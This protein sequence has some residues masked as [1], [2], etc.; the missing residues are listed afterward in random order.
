MKINSKLTLLFLLISLIPLAVI[1]IFSYSMA[2]KALTQQVLN[3]L[4]SL[5]VVQKNRVESI[6]AQNLERLVLVSSR[7]QL[8]LSLE[9]FIRDPRSEYQD[10]MN[11][12]LLDARSSISGF[13]NISVLTLNGKVVASTDLAKIYTEHSDEEF[14]I[15]GQIENSADIFFLDEDQNL[16]AYLSGPLYLENKLL[17]VVVIE[18]DLDNI[19]SLVKD[20]S[21]LGETGETLLAKIDGNGDALFLTPLRFDEKAALR[22]TVPKD[23][24][25][26]PITQAL[27]KN[28]WLFSDAVDYRR[29]P[30]LAATQYIGKTDWGLVAKVDKAEAFAPIIQLRNLVVLIIFVSSIVVIIFSFYV[31]R[32]ITKPIINLTQMASKISEGDLS[33]RAEVTSIDEIGI[34]AQ[35]F[36]QMAD[37]LFEYITEHKRAEEELRSSREQLR[38]LSAHLQ[39]VREEERT[40]IAREI[41][42]ELGQALTALKMDLSWLGNRLPKDEKSLLEKAKSMSELIDMT[43]QTVKRISAELRPGLLDDLGLAVAIEWQ[44]EEFQNRTGIKCEITLAPKDIILDQDRSTAIFRI[45]Q[46]TLT[47]VARHA[48]ATRVKV[49]LKEDKGKLVLK[50]RD[51]GIGITQEQISAPKSFGLIGMQERAHFWGGKVKISGIR[52]KG[53]TVTVS[54]PLDKKGETQ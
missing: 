22:R 34:L 19:I 16:K 9:D 41:H 30:V 8:R 40:L 2:K 36:N 26:A 25:D 54:I 5:V 53:T 14:F 23:D 32:S 27:L 50:V 4:E 10:M 3:Q 52:N 12:I 6:V 17:G 45:F 51:N 15:R 43:I 44:A 28:V 21:G 13:R 47:N 20:Y 33:G 42:D 37:N 24:L 18:S 7:T 1:G 49:S 35:T 39:S 38:N 48:N 46:E 29:E 31:A 11:R